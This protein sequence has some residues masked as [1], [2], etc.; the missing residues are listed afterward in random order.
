M[1]AFGGCDPHGGQGIG[2][3]DAGRS[4]TALLTCQWQDWRQDF[5]VPSGIQFFRMAGNML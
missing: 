5:A 2:V 1:G 3:W 4:E